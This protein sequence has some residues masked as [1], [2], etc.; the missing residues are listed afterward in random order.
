LPAFAR[1][2]AQQAPDEIALT[3]SDRSYTW[4]QVDE[5][6]ERGA[7]ALQALD[8]GSE[9]RI[10]VFAEN[11]AEAVLAHVI[12]LLGSTSVVPISFHLTADEVAYILEDSGTGLLFVGPHTAARGL[13]AAR[14]AGVKT[15]VGWRTGDVEGVTGW[16]TWLAGAPPSQARTDLPPLPNL[17][18]TS[19]TTGRPKGTDLPPTMFAGG[20][21]IEEHLLRLAEVPFVA[22][23]THLVTGPLYHTGPLLGVRLLAGGTPIVVL[24]RFRP[25]DTLAAIARHA[26]ASTVMVPTHFV[27]LLA[28]PADVRESADLSS[29]KL[30][31]HTGASCPVDVKQRMIAWWGPVLTEAYGASEVGTTCVI[32]SPEWL[33]HPGSVGRCVPPFSALVVDEEGQNVPAGT[34]GRLYFA[35]ETG[36]GIIYHN[37]PEKSAAA[38]LRPGVFTLGEIGYVD[39]DGYVYITDRFSDM[40]VSG[41]V[42]LY[43]AEPENVLIEHPE[44]ADVACIGVPHAEM[45]EELVGLVVPRDADAPPDP[46]ELVAFCRERL[47]H[48][49]CPRRIELVDSV[50]RNTM[51]KVN[52]RKL[53]DAHVGAHG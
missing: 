17:M 32:T 5:L 41:G 20:S 36:R 19:G 25:E 53:R 14:K 24:Q 46:A 34:E 28:L 22:L 30:V 47:S 52:K 15:V 29:L 18:Y 23:G 10:A 44:V 51:G 9:R 45:G 21:T 43:P 33:E 27:R 35:D 42:N 31:F 38:H 49:K 48:F 12:G 2:R 8:L 37:A 13:E 26:V 11:A 50:G 39:P 3:D 40:V 16:D 6:L 4:A 7:S 1:E